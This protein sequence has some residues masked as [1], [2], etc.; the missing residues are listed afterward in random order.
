MLRSNG[1]NRRAKLE[2]SKLKQPSCSTPFPMAEP[3]A[4]YFDVIGETFLTEPEVSDVSFQN[5]DHERAK[6][7]ASVDKA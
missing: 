7:R 4:L 6:S 2:E 3:Q 1:V 5:Q